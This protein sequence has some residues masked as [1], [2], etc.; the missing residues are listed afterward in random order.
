MTRAYYDATVI[1]VLLFNTDLIIDL[2]LAFAQTTMACK[3]RELAEYLEEQIDS[4]IFCEG[5]FLPG[6]RALCEQ[7]QLS[8]VTV[9]KGLNLLVEA[10]RIRAIPGQGYQVLGE[11][12]MAF[13][14]RTHLI[15]GVFPTTTQLQHNNPYVSTPY[16]LML[17]IN[18][19][20]NKSGYCLTFVNSMDNLLEERESIRKLIKLGV[21][22]LLIMP[23]FTQGAFRS[24][25]HDLGN[26][27]FFL[28]LYQNGLPIVLMD[29]QLIGTGIP[30]V[31]NDDIMGGRMQA[32][33][34]LKRGYRRVIYFE[35]ASSQTG[36]F[37]HAGYCLAME[38]AG[39]K[40]LQITPE[41]PIEPERWDF[42]DSQGDDAIRQL[43]P[44]ITEDTG[45]ITTYRLAAFFDKFFPGHRFGKHRVEWCCYDI[46]SM[47]LQ[48]PYPYMLRPTEKIGELAAK[49][50][51]AILQNDHMTEAKS[52]Q[53]DMLSPTLCLPNNP[54]K[55]SANCHSLQKRIFRSASQKTV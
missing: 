12:S 38:D 13:R 32:E 47:G 25:K 6:E 34:F 3:Y 55:H 17:G 44:Q 5:S 9:R 46:P 16:Q 43:L 26:Y 1:P 41:I 8:R 20:L 27:P 51:L 30:A 4:G 15:G 2:T 29:R 45:L 23:S 42:P 53:V 49:R 18:K 37:R 28:E 36:H 14:R 22:G 19:A 33:Y 21:D 35:T 39:L 52:K 54:E 10:C 50:L 11:R 31:F 24:M 40:P 48:Q 7:F